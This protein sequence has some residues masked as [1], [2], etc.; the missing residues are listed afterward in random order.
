MNWGEHSG[1]D[2]RDFLRTLAAGTLGLALPRS[3]DSYFSRGRGRDLKHWAWITTD[4]KR[5]ESDWKRTFSLARQAGLRAVVPEVYNGRFAYYASDHLPVKE[6][7]MEKILP[8]AKAEGLEFHAW[9]WVM[10]CNNTD[11]STLHPEW[12]CVNRK[13]ESAVTKPAYV[14]Y[15]KFLCP[16]RPEVRAFIQKTVSELAQYDELDGIHLDYVRYPDVILAEALQPKYGIVQDREYPEYDYCYCEVCRRDFRTEYGI[17]LSSLK[18]PTA[19]K[20]WKQFRYDRITRLVNEDLIPIAR[21]R[22]KNVTAAVFPN[23]ENVRQQWPRWNLDA[24]L[25]M[26]YNGFYN[27]GLPWIKEETERGIEQLRGN[28]PVYSG[29]FVPAMDPETLEKAIEVSLDGGAG[30]V[31]LFSLQAMT[32]RHWESFGKAVAASG[33]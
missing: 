15:Y 14:D 12:Y 22:G 1:M 4:V 11:F 10:P 26:L 8:L 29:L 31:S 9:I 32:E 5:S 19:S 2:K 18:D 25:P 6:N 21:K 3:F 16:S 7:W 20:E 33:R 24:V 13:G 23:W 27:K 30:G 17:D 28:I